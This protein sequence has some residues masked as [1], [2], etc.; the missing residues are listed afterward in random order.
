MNKLVLGVISLDQAMQFWNQTRVG[1]KAKL[2]T[3]DTAVDRLGSLT[4]RCPTPGTDP[5]ASTRLVRCE[6]AVAADGRVLD[7]AKTALA[8]WAMH[9]QHMEMLRKGEMTPAQ[10]T[11]LWLQSWHEGQAQVTAYHAATKDAR[12]RHCSLAQAS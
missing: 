9:V 2:T 4:I 11:Q 8:T 10:A 1:A 6:R 5:S 12:S 3:F 7:L